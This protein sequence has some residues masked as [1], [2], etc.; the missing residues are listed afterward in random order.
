MTSRHDQEFADYIAVRLEALRR[1]A[2]LLCQ[3]WHRADDLAQAAAIKAYT[4]WAR[5]ERA[6]NTDAYVN[7][8]LVREFLHERRT[9]WARRVRLTEP[10]EIMTSAADQDGSL[11]LRA[12]VAALPPRQ[13]S[14]LVL[15]F[16]CDLTVYQT[17]DALGCTTGTVKSQTAKALDSLR[18]AMGG[19][20]QAGPGGNPATHVIGIP[21]A[22]GTE[23]HA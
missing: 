17:A 12:A 19:A 8:I 22:E 18:R 16:Y 14:V 3:D 20:A 13:R 6:D 15:R 7:A 2:F 5:A 21:A 9:G 23:F 1:L 4:H 10:P 11:D